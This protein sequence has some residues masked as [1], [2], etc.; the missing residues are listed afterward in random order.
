MSL[1]EDQELRRDLALRVLKMCAEPR[2][3]LEIAARLERYVIQGRPTPKQ[4]P[5]LAE[6]NPSPKNPWKPHYRRRWTEGEDQHL[7]QLWKTPKLAGF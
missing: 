2:R 7:G 6:K 4:S 1:R 3:T 5:S